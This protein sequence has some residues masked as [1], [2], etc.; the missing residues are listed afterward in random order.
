[1]RRLSFERPGRQGCLADHSL[2]SAS[3]PFAAR[4]KSARGLER[5]KCRL[6]PRGVVRIAA[7]RV[8]LYIDRA[9][10]RTRCSGADAAVAGQM[11]YLGRR[12][13][14][15]DVLFMDE[16]AWTSHAAEFRRRYPAARSLRHLGGK[17]AEGSF[18]GSLLNHAQIRHTARFERIAQEG[19]DLFIANHVSAAPLALALPRS[20]KKVLA[21]RQLET[22]SLA[23]GD[24]AKPPPKDPLLA[25]RNA[26]LRRTEFELFRLFDAVYFSNE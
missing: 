6:K 15:V 4:R 21:A 8:L 9:F 7:M 17:Q 12:G 24:S 16:R 10:A 3:G 18:R 23:P 19:H 22:D 14:D 2:S 1:L 13:W 20:C 11:A 26:F 5:R 25:A